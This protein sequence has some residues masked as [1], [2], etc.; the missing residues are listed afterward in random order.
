M[1]SVIGLKSVSFCCDNCAI[2]VD[3]I[4]ERNPCIMLLPNDDCTY[5]K[6][7]RKNVVVNCPQVRFVHFG[8]GLSDLFFL[9]MGYLWGAEIGTS[10]NDL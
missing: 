7:K 3:N 4:K 1:F 6:A 10:T 9:P 2:I 5:C 8:V